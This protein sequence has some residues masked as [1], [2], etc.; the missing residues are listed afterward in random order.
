MPS[1][2]NTR[3]RGAGP[4]KKQEEPQV[5]KQATETEV[6]AKTATSTTETNGT[7]TMAEEKTP[8][9]DTLQL[10]AGW[11]ICLSSSSSQHHG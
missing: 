9:F 6:T 8:H 10:H 2:R 5:K 1:P 11:V 3:K 4:A 7:G